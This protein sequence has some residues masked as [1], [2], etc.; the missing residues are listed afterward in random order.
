MKKRYRLHWAN[1]HDRGPR[2]DFK[3]T[4]YDWQRGHCCPVAYAETRVA[5][6]ELCDFLNRQHDRATGRAS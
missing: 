2:P 1:E 4:V 5:G 3:W 6:R